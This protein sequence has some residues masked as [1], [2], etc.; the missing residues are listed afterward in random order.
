MLTAFVIRTLS[1]LALLALSILPVWAD[2]D[3]SNGRPI[4]LDTAEAIGE[5]ADTFS[6][7]MEEAVKA[8]LV[9]KDKALFRLYWTDQSTKQLFRRTI[10]VSMLMTE[11]PMLAQA[12]QDD[13]AAARNGPVNPLTRHTVDA[14]AHILLDLLTDDTIGASAVLVARSLPND[15]RIERLVGKVLVVPARVA[16]VADQRFRAGQGGIDALIG[17]IDL[18]A[19]FLDG[20]GFTPENRSA[21]EVSSAVDSALKIITVGLILAFAPEAS[22]FAL[23]GANVVGS[24][25]NVLERLWLHHVYDAYQSTLKGL[26]DQQGVGDIL[27]AAF[28]QAQKTRLAKGMSPITFEAFVGWDPNLILA[29]GTAKI[30]ELNA[31]YGFKTTPPRSVDPIEVTVHR[32]SEHYREVCRSG[33]CAREDITPPTVSY[34][35]YEADPVSGKPRQIWLSAGTAANPGATQAA[36]GDIGA[37]IT[38]GTALVVV[39]RPTDDAVAKAIIGRFGAKDARVVASVGEAAAGAGQNKPPPVVVAVENTDEDF[40]RAADGYLRR[41]VC[42]SV[43][44]PP[45]RVF[46]PPPCVGP[47]CGPQPTSV[48]GLPGGGGPNGSL[49]Q[50]AAVPPASAPPPQRSSSATPP[51]PGWGDQDVGGVLL[52][53][54]GVPLRSDRSPEEIRASFSLMLEGN[55]AGLSQVAF[56]RVIT[57]IWAV[58]LSPEPPGISINPIAPG[59]D[60]HLVQYI[61]NVVNTDLGRV[62]READ[63]TMKKW[64]VGTEAPDIPG[65]DTPDSL[66][67]RYGT[68][69]INVSRRFWFVP[70]DLQFDITDRSIR[71][72]SGTMKLLTETAM[73]HHGGTPEKADQD[74]ADFFSKHYVRIAERYPIYAELQEYGQLVALARFLKQQQIPLLWFLLANRNLIETENAAGAVDELV[75]GSRTFPGVDIHGGVNLGGSPHYVWDAAALDAMRTAQRLS[76][77]LS[78]PHAAPRFP[79]D[80]SLA[81][82]ETQRL[83]LQQRQYTVRPAIGDSPVVDRYGRY[84]K[85]DLAVWAVPKGARPDAMGTDTKAPASDE[86][87]LELVRY[88]DPI[89]PAG[90]DFG[91]GWRLLIPYEI[92]REETSRISFRGGLIP[93]RVTV[94]DLLSGARELLTFSEDRYALA[95]WFPQDPKQSRLIG[96]V[97]R[98]D[99]G[100]RLVDKL[101]SEFEFDPFGK[102]VYMQLSP[103]YHVQYVRSIPLLDPSVHAAYKLDKSGIDTFDVA[104]VTVPARLEIT[105]STHREEFIFDRHADTLSWQ[106][107]AGDRSRYARIVVAA[108]GAFHLV[109]RSGRTIMFDQDGGV[110]AIL[111]ASGKRPVTALIQDDQRIDLLYRLNPIT[112][113]LEISRAR[114]S[115]GS[116]VEVRYDYDV[117]D[118]LV[119]LHYQVARR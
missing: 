83:T 77:T 118:Q 109:E 112:E 32:V 16:I 42:G 30:A 87:M 99:G 2:D 79:A 54:V 119:G 43:R 36:L 29:V 11:L 58:Y 44:C 50:P 17:V 53:G 19:L 108:D 31:Q 70:D 52:T 47:Q 9:S 116:S 56:Q 33:V 8:R 105:G 68:H 115:G 1:A 88:F 24:V 13:A 110:L 48:V 114:T 85:T 82:G 55:G 81:S 76:P 80:S 65:F 69:S 26:L 75:K 57:A 20:R 45:P 27:V 21:D 3:T 15:T 49:S 37:T 5:G 61:G 78:P 96:L 41:R 92:A 14:S 113:E 91:H 63:Y 38:P 71:F 95:G 102:L 67:R 97:L 59:V 34:E 72:A 62:M 28:V 101:E 111:P 103:T 23:A 90:G 84:Y 51:P 89:R 66:M 74:F 18:T 98:S 60:K 64:A 10:T 25:I 4:S 22:P 46:P 93:Q 12:W 86:P 107:E 117:D 6:R 35:W 100:S 106:P 94:I 73:E 40:E 7:F 39:A 104:S